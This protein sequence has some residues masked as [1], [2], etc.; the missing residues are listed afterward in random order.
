MATINTG[1]RLGSWRW[2]RRRWRLV[3]ALELGV[4]CVFAME[5][6]WNL[7]AIDCAWCGRRLGCREIDELEHDAKIMGLLWPRVWVTRSAIKRLQAAG[8]FR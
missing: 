2:W 8:Y 4:C 5:A 3:L 7:Y 1:P 6:V